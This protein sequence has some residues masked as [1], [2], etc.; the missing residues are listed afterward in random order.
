MQIKSQKDFWSGLMF[1]GI[2]LAFAVGSLTYSFGSSARPGPAYFPFGLGVLMSLLGGLVL[3]TSM[4]V[5]TDD[6]G[7]IGPWAW[8]P[9]LVVV[10]SLVL[11]GFAL[12]RLGLIVSLPLL[13]FI[14]SLAGDEFHWKEAL[15]NAAVLTFMSWG[16]FVKGLNLTLPVWPTFLVG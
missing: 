8:R 5:E 9:L 6:G 15:F 14:V 16:I 3:F 4:T 2:G 13:V 10:G 11:F 12:P 7:R 1:V